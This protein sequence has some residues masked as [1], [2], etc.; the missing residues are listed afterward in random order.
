MPVIRK[1]CKKTGEK[2]V[3]PEEE[4]ALR[5]RLGIEGEP[6]YSPVFKFMQ[7]GAFWQ[8]WNLF[9][10]KC[11]KTGKEIISVFSENCP[12]PV[13]HK[14]EWIKHADPPGA[15]FDES[16]DVFPQMWDFFQKSPIFHNVGSGNENCEYTDDW[17]Y[18]RNCYL[19]HSGADNEDLRYCYRALDSKDCQFCV[20]CEKLELC[21]DAIYSVNCFRC[22]YVLNSRQCSE[23]AFLYDCRNCSN[24]MFSWNLRNKKYCFMNEQLSKEEYEKK[25]AEWDLSSRK[26]YDEAKEVFSKIVKEE[27]FHRALF[28]DRSEN[29]TGDHLDEAKN[30]TNCYFITKQSEDCINCTRHALDIKDALDNV[31]FAVYGE[32]GYYNCMVQDHTYDMKFCY[33]TIQCKMGE[34]SAHCFQCSNIFGCCGLSGKK[35]HIFNRPY[36]KEDYEALKEKI[37]AKMKE[38]GEYGE[39]FPGY[40]CAN[41]YEES[42]SNIYWPL[43][44]E[45]KEKYGFRSVE[46]KKREKPADFLDASEVPDSGEDSDDTLTQKKFW[47]SEAGKPFQI[48][49]TDITFSKK[50]ACPLP[51]SFYSGR[52]QE[53]FKWLYYNGKTRTAKCAKCGSE[54]P[55][56]WPSEYD[57]RILCEKDYLEALI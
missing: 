48:F 49:D 6:E 8:H 37:I 1:I 30:C 28:I 16:K 22:K 43:S 54:T 20:F 3:V 47:D 9:K 25:T 26:K 39:F 40:F 15:D 36:S 21:M 23:S 19:C 42:W 18:C 2:F 7:L 24:C 35:Y 12:Y 50:M 14:D 5:K 55:T 31:G 29:C 11:G 46:D 34:Y 38:T 53:N 51:N 57:G 45:E 32:R 52:L 27:A 33:N 44:K 41:T 10:R 4:M 56:S 17:W 13:W